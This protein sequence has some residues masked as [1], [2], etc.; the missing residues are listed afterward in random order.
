VAMLPSISGNAVF[1][2]CY[3][4]VDG[5]VLR[6]WCCWRTVSLGRES[7]AVAADRA[8][9]GSIC[10]RIVVVIIII[11][12]VIIKMA[13]LTWHKWKSLQNHGT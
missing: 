3:Q 7:L 5:T 6:Y 9:L 11:I 8:L 12:I 13:G 4:H 1:F 10:R 2:Q